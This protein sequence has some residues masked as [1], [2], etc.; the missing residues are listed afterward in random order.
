MIL[1][2][3]NRGQQ[4]I[5][6]EDRGRDWNDYFRNLG[7]LC[8]SVPDRNSETELGETEKVVLIAR[9]RGEHSRLVPQGPC[10]PWSQ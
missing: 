10:P 3:K 4:R 7:C 1:I 6:R 8:T 2:L 9:Q 5:P